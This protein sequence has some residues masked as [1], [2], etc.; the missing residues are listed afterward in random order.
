[1]ANILSKC[2]LISLAVTFCFSLLS[3]QTN[4]KHQASALFNTKRNY[5]F[6]SGSTGGGDYP[7]GGFGLNLSR[8][9][10]NGKTMA[11]IGVHYI[12][13]TQ[14]GSGIGGNDYVQIFPLMVDIRQMFMESRDGRFATFIIADGG[15]V[16]SITGNGED[17]EGP[18]QF[19]NGWAI[20]PGIGFRFNIFENVGLMFDITWL[21]HSSPRE[22]LPPVEKKGHKHWD[23]GLVRVNVFF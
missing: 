15:Y 9:F 17:I 4:E 18:Y 3:A 13:N 21:H 12:G 5:I 14:D 10:F 22:W 16:I 2:V 19:L 7:F 8:Q 6:V 20:N 11:G 23:V 1:M